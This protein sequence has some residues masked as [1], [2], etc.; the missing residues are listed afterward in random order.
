MSGVLVESI[1]CRT[2]TMNCEQDAVKLCQKVFPAQLTYCPGVKWPQ[3]EADHSHLVSKFSPRFHNVVS[4]SLFKYHAKNK[5]GQ[6]AVWLH[7]FFM[8]NWMI[9]CT[10]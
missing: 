2:V 8:L 7:E 5:Y 6:L 10:S 3:R 9:R 4:N 1:T